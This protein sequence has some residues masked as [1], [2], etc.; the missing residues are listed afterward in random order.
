MDSLVIPCQIYITNI[1]ICQIIKIYI[2]FMLGIIK[3][4]E[5]LYNKGVSTTPDE[6]KEVG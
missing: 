1:Q 4:K 2:I 3:E 6:C 5:M